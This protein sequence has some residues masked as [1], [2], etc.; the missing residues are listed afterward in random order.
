[1]EEIGDE[2]LASF[3]PSSIDEAKLAKVGKAAKTDEKTDILVPIEES[4][5]EDDGAEKQI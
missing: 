3:M 2:L 1:L 4:S 5:S